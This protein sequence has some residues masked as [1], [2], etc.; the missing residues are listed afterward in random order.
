L[1]SDFRHFS[2]TEVVV[3]TGADMAPSHLFY[4][5]GKTALPDAPGDHVMFPW[6]WEL[7][8]DGCST[9]LLSSADGWTWSRVPGGP[10][11]S[12]GAPGAGDGG[13]VV[14]SGNLLEYPGDRWGIGYSGNPIPHKYPGRDVRQRKGLFPGV[15]SVSGLAVWPRGRLVALASDG[16]GELSTVAV[17]PP[18]DAIRLNAAVKPTGH[19][20]V[21]VRL[22]GKGDVAGRSF[23]DADRI[24]GDSLSHKVSWKGE[25]SLKHG[26]AAV[27]LRFQMKQAKLFAV[28]FE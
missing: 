28:E 11:I 15:E 12:T 16:E 20:R 9:W 22:Y 19:I 5:N 1:S 13:Y 24:V 4:T 7:E 2:K 18:G 17:V 10:V 27:I 14:A 3:A 6:V 21:A 8:S 25:T 26:G 23:E